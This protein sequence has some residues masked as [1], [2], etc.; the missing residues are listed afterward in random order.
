MDFQELLYL[1]TGVALGAAMA[2][3]M[4][5]YQEWKHKTRRAK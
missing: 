3:S 4:V 1:L 2:F 5:K